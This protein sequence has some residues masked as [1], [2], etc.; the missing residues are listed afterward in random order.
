MRSANAQGITIYPVHPE[1][2]QWSAPDPSVSGQ[3]RMESSLE[4]DLGRA[5]IDN[6]VLQNES[7][8]LKEVADATGGVTAWGSA[9]IAK[10]LPRVTDDLET[11]YSLGYRT[12][13]T[14]RD[15][16]RSIV[17]KT[18]NPAYVVRS[19]RQVVEKSDTTQMKDRVM[20][21]LFQRVSSS[22]MSIPFDVAVGEVKKTGRNRWSIPLKL[23]VP[24]RS[25]TMLPKGRVEQGEFSVFVVTGGG[26]GVMSEVDRHS[27]PFE[28]A[29]A[30]LEHA[31]SSYFTYELSLSVDQLVDRLS[32][33]VMDEVGKEY[34]LKR[35]SL[36]K[37]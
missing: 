18:K 23:R 10:L 37:R 9:N 3:S 26:L 7:A 16:T 19:R 5:G 34:G 25:L 13:L 1:G 36:P 20:A 31:K 29:S 30:E 2:L 33:G 12:P 32:V 35:F 14:G 22:S 17:V 27:Q 6:L 24:I 4:D 15:S 11:Y 28:V 8:A 21:N